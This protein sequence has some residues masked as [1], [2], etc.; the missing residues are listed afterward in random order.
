LLSHTSFQV[1]QY[2][3]AAATRA[4]RIIV[5]QPR[6]LATIALCK[7]VAEELERE[8]LVGYGIGWALVVEGLLN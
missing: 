6:R 3:L 8:D 1:P 7:R 5:T 2:L 4:V